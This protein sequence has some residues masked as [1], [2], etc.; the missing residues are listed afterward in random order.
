VVVLLLGA[1]APLSAQRLER[2][3]D[4]A[5]PSGGGVFLASALVP[6]LGQYRLGEWRWV[7]YAAIE[8]WGWLTYAERAVRAERLEDDYRDLAW[9][10]ARRISVGARRDGEFEYY[11]RMTQYEE[12]GAFDA[13]AQLPGIQPESD[14]NTFNGSVWQLAQE[15]YFPAGDTL[16]PTPAERAAAVA[17]YR[18][19]AIAPEYAWSW[20]GAPLERRVFSDLIRR[21]DRAARGA[22]TMIGV[23]LANHFL[24]AADALVTARLRGDGA[25]GAEDRLRLRLRP[26][27]RGGS[28]HYFLEVHLTTP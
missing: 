19:R 8:A 17:Y 14:P 11:E 18:E 4:A 21:S 26:D 23:L 3:P 24:S 27:A 6:G 12:S 15:I 13:D 28:R 10:V 7:G 16:Q 5:A 1:A 25:E 22:T 9:Q 2:F 20:A